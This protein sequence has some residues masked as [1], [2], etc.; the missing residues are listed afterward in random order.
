MT[1][2]KLNFVSNPDHKA[3]DLLPP[4]IYDLSE[5]EFNQFFYEQIP[6]NRREI[7][8]TKYCRFRKIIKNFIGSCHWINGSFVGNKP[9]PNDIDVVLWVDSKELNTLND[10]QKKFLKKMCHE[11]PCIGRNYFCTHAFIFEVVGL[12]HPNYD[13]F[14]KNR[15]YWLET[16]SHTKLENI[17][18]GFVTININSKTSIAP[19]VL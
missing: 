8:C 14:L 4:G 17:S 13:N 7:I 12:N 2:N 9:E 1:L 10:K 19:K 6:T 15:Q 5:T 3:Y 18:K 11:E 16:W